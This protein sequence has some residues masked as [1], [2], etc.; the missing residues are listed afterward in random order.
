MSAAMRR[1]LRLIAAAALVVASVALGGGAASADD[2][3][4]TIDSFNARIEIQRDGRILVT[5]AIDVDF[6]SLERHGIFRDIPVE[7]DWPDRARTVRV[8]EL[9]VV[10]VRDDRGNAIPY[11]TSR[12][13]AD[14]QIRIGDADRTVTGKQHYRLTYL[15]G[16]TLNAFPDHDELYWNATGD[17]WPVPILASSATVVGP[18]APTAYECFYGFSG[19][20]A[21][22]AQTPT[23]RGR[24]FRAPRALAPGEQLTFVVSL[25]KGAVP[26]PQPILHDRPRDVEE[27]FDLTPLTLGLGVVVM[28]VGLW[29]VLWRWL[30]AGRDQRERETIVPEY[31]PPESLRPAELGVLVDEH[32][33]TKDVTATIVDL[34]VRGYLTITEQPKEGI[35][36]SK[37]WTLTKKGGDPAALREY[38]RTIYDGLFE[39]RDEVKLS[40]LKKHF[41]TT[42]AKAQRELYRETVDRKWFPADP[43][44]VRATY[45]VLG[46]AFVVGAG[47]LTWLLGYLAGAGVVG[48]AGIVPALALI[49]ASPV[50]PSKTRV[51]AELLRRTLGFRQYME[52]AEKDRQ[53]FAEKEHIFAQ[54]LP[55]A[56]V[57]GCV[58]RWAR[59]FEGI[60][61]KAA[62]AGWY[63]GSS[64]PTTFS[65]ADLSSQLS[66]FSN[67]VSTAIAS[68]PGSSGGSGFGGGA[69]GGGG[70]GGGGS[71]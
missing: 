7:Y 58:E 16:G 15:V 50:M 57:F 70:G 54:Y 26:D 30:S 52:V 51:G 19:S 38:E 41:Y 66:S 4:W 64:L 68:T 9:Q 21:G 45:A 25:P 2:T 11:S 62:T 32:A 10:T 6:D 69:G 59:A 29:L 34:A 18:V 67:Q 71:W 49:V 53:A 27:F 37:D 20:Q 42:L 33:D 13:G 55:Y 31:E 17:Q 12:D 61:M 8:Y 48:L 39:D 35:F 43:S 24:V 22:C 28:L 46:V 14:V 36:G 3:G 60:D 65:A 23:D 5:E 40:A 56:I 47:V 44:R 63:Y 1:A